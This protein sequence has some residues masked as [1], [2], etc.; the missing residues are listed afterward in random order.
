L[1][2]AA[3]LCVFATVLVA[4]RLFRTTTAS[5]PHLVASLLFI[6]RE[7]AAGEMQ[8]TLALGWSL[9]FEMFFYAA[10]AVALGISRRWSPLICAGWLVAFVVAIHAIGTESEILSFY[11]RPIVLEFALGILAFYLFGWCGARR[12]GLAR[13]GWLKWALLGVLVGGLALL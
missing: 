3:T 1:Y 6:P 12:D 10:F 2:W 7:S 4:P 8:P 11:A 5:V 13:I 9:N